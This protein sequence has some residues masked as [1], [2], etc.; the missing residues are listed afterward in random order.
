MIDETG[1]LKEIKG[2]GQKIPGRV[3]KFFDI[4]LN[5]D[6]SNPLFVVK[7]E[8][9]DK[10]FF[11]NIEQ[12][13]IKEIEMQQEINSNQLNYAYMTTTNDQENVLLKLDQT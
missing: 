10:L 3:A 11:C 5:Q 12:L 7:N 9:Q 2:K 6:K 1:E 8:F 13:K 4:P